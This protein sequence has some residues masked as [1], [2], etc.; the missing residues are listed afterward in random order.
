MA[1]QV[2]VGLS[3]LCLLG[4]GVGCSSAGASDVGSATSDYSSE[5]A[6][7]PDIP[8]FTAAD[9]VEAYSGR[10]RASAG[11]AAFTESTAN[12]AV[13]SDASA[14]L[15]FNLVGAPP[16]LPSIGP[17]VTAAAIYFGQ[18][19]DDTVKP[20]TYSCATGDATVGLQAYGAPAGWSVQWAKTC[21]VIIDE[22][23]PTDDPEYVRV[24]GR[25]TAESS[26]PGGLSSPLRGAFVA[27][28]PLPLRQR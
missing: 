24:Y 25:F 22:V 1:K 2:V 21:S 13:N 27:I 15:K 6:A 17:G 3:L 20:G 11:A 10:M 7:T 28:T 23:S 26:L 8:V 16:G 4:T 12:A 14:P 18:K 5:R 9:T 19:D